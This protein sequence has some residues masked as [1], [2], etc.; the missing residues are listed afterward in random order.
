MKQ[1]KCPICNKDSFLIDKKMNIYKCIPCNHTSTII[2]K[3]KH[4]NYSKEY[5]MNK[6]KN[7]FNNPN[8]KLFNLIYKS[9]RPRAGTKL[10]D[11]GCGK[12]DFLKTK[13]KGKFNFVCSFMVIEHLNDPKL[14]LKKIG[15]ILEDKGVFVLNTIN[16]DSLLYRI[17]RVLKNVRFSVAYNWLYS[18]HHHQHFTNQ[19]LKK[20]IYLNGFEVM[21]HK[22]HNYPF[23]A[24]DIPKSNFLFEK[25]YKLAVIIIFILSKPFG[26]GMYQTLICK[27]RTK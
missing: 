4:E 7:W 18:K 23:N 21:S 16:N 11:I 27:K 3:D 15:Y 17:A 19:S 26:L 25:L 22:N 8:V 10:L 13:I 9:L 20:I 14:L 1:A 12:G 5:F 2:Q 24:I 6:H